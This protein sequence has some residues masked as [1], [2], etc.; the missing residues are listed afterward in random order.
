MSHR[1][2]VTG[3]ETCELALALDAL[4]DTDRAVAMVESIQHLRDP[5]GAYWTGRVLSDG[6]R[7][8]VERSCWTSAAVILAADAISR[9]TPGGGI[10]ADLEQVRIPTPNSGRRG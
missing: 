2:W 9:A 10:F 4:G 7:W 8:P 3:A 6:K 1:P 5:G